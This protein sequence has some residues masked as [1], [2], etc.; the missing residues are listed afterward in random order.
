MTCNVLVYINDANQ[1]YIYSRKAFQS[2]KKQQFITNRMLWS[3]VFY[4]S[5]GIYSAL[6]FQRE[7]WPGNG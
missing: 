2:T 3:L 7:V 4:R 5:V 6:G 1:L